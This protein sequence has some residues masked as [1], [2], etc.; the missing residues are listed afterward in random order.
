MIM[1]LELAKILIQR[2]Q[3]QHL[4]WSTLHAT[5]YLSSRSK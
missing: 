5:V 3:V 4:Q 2:T 1:L